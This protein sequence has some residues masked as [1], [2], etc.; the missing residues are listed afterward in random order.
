MGE[1]TRENWD[2]QIDN[3]NITAICLLCFDGKY[4]SVKRAEVIWSWI[5]THKCEGRR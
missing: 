3:V 2:I 1:K 4:T 5:D